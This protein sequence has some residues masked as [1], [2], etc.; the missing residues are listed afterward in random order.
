MFAVFCRPSY[1]RELWFPSRWLPELKKLQL[2]P[3]PSPEWVLKFFVPWAPL[4]VWWSLWSPQ[5][6]ILKCIQ[7]NQ[8]TEIQLSNIK[9]IK[10]M[11]PLKSVCEPQVKNPWLKPL[12][13]RSLIYFNFRGSTKNEF[14]IGH[15]CESINYYVFWTNYM[16]ST[17]VG[18]MEKNKK[19]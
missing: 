13:P 1:Q 2:F 8:F 7:Q 6:N 16:P 17:V 12:V 15:V 4:E 9:M 3:R 14:F 19:K 11:D 10:F 5:N 18:A